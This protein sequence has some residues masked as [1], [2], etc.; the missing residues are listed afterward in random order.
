MYE[1]IRLLDIS[2]I[3]GSINDGAEAPL[4]TIPVDV[5]KWLR[6]RAT[7]NGGTQSGEVVR[8]LREQMERLKSIRRNHK[9]E[10]HTMTDHKAKPLAH[11]LV[12]IDLGEGDDDGEIDRNL[13]TE[14]L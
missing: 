7:Y 2:I 5:R 10:E 11:K 1:G 6:D 12:A 14:E 8:A 13:V 4:V 9:G 3:T